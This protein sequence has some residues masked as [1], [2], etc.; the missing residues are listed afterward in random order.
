MA[1]EQPYK[2]FDFRVGVGVE[3]SPT[4]LLE[5]DAIVSDPCILLDGVVTGPEHLALV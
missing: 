3:M 4:D 2:A 1:G 5:V